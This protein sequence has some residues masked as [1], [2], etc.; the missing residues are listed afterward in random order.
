[1]VINH[2]HTPELAAKVVAGIDA[3]GGTALAIAA[4]LARRAE[5]QGMV[6]RTLAE[7][8]RWDILVNN[9][10]VAITKP[11]A[12]ITEAELDRS[13]A[14]NVK[15]AFQGLQLARERLA[16]PFSQVERDVAARLRAADQHVTV[17]RIVNRVG[18]VVDLP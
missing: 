13:F 16:D 12:Q 4:D 18:C 11:F 10:A 14:A 17:R 2:P 7:Y 9:A 15:G 5:Y 1:V 6:A 8:G 3:D